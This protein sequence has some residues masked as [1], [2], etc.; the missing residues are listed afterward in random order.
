MKTARVDGHKPAQL[1]MDETLSLGFTTYKLLRI[2]LS[3]HGVRTFSGR[4]CAHRGSAH[5]GSCPP[6]PPPPPRSSLGSSVCLV[7][8]PPPT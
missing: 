1:G 3:I 6:T 7:G 2:V 8:T 5:F 4:I